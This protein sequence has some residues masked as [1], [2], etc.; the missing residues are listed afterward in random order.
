[1]IVTVFGYLILISRDFYDFISPFSVLV[2]IDKIYQPLKTVFD[3]IFKHCTV[4]R[5]FNSLHAV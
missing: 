1:M 4:R 5:I 3:H 2:S